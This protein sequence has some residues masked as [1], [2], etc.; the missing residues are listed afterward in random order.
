MASVYLMHRDPRLFSDPDAFIPERFLEARKKSGAW[1]PFGG[2]V[3]R[4][5]GASFAQLEMKVV[6]AP[7]SR[8]STLRAV[9]PEPEPVRRKRFTFAPARQARAL[10][11]A[12]AHPSDP[13]LS[14][15][16][17]ATNRPDN[18]PIGAN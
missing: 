9:D 8:L 13:C 6:L 5:L 12:R 1:I 11:E 15:P 16:D 3:R 2:G 14:V 17:A 4:C 7:S 10:V 18:P